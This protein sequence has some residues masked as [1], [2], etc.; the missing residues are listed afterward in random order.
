MSFLIATRHSSMDKA[1]KGQRSSV[2]VPR[3]PR[4]SP[5]VASNGR[6]SSTMHPPSTGTE[7]CPGWKATP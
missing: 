6:T 7:E 2:R 4:C 5:R 1:E 3:P